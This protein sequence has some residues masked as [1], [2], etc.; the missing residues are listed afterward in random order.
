MPNLAFMDIWQKLL[1]EIRAA[2]FEPVRLFIEPAG[3][4]FVLYLGTALA[5]AVV[6]YLVARRRNPAGTPPLLSYLFPRKVYLSPSTMADYRFFIIDRVLSFLLVPFC[7]VTTA[8]VADASLQL[9]EGM[10]GPATQPILTPGLATTLLITLGTVLAVDLALWWIHY[11]HH[12]VPVLWEFH[13]VHHSAEAMTPITAYRMHPVEI[14]LNINLTSLV[15]GVV[16]AVFAYLTAGSVS[17]FMVAGVDVVTLMFYVF[18]FNLRHSHIPMAYPR[19]LSYIYV[20]PWM[21]QVHH[22]R[23]KRHL[24]TNMGFNFAIWDWMFGTLYVPR[25]GETFAIGLESGESPAFHSVRALYLLPF[26]NIAARLWQRGSAGE[27][28]R[29]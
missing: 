9:I 12:R 28:R 24:D 4:V 6:V 17:I 11:L 19:W 25:R 21:H 15:G 3:R 7:V 8:Y 23:E 16:L 20:S 13:K 22:S 10:L 2:L 14:I 5:C 27:V 26:R 29:P 1:V 18:G